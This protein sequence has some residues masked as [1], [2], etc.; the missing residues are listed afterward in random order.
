GRRSDA[1][2]RALLRR[3]G[4]L[5]RPPLGIPG[6]P[7]RTGPGGTSSRRTGARWRVCRS[8]R[9]RVTGVPGTRPVGRG[10][11]RPQRPLRR[12]RAGHPMARSRVVGGAAGV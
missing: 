8:G 12:Q 3:G 6:G 11:V 7:S 10:G 4:R 1:T 5:R 9:W 2:L